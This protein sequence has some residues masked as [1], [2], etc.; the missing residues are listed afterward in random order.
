MLKDQCI[1]PSVLNVERIVR[2][3]SSQSQE[4]QFTV[5]TVIK[6]C[7][8]VVKYKR[9]SK[10]KDSGVEWIGEI[11]EE[12]EINKIK[13]Y[14]EIKSGKTLQSSKKNEDDIQVPYITAG[15][16]FWDKIEIDDLSMMNVS[17]EEIKMYQTLKIPMI[18]SLL[19]L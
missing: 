1:L 3:H 19:K 15:N 10:Y 6:K 17:P 11:P 7:G 8:D 16:V 9:Y 14:F 12:W 5:K 2:F 13:F 4:D 18:L